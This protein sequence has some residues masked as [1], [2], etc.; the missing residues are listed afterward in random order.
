MNDSYSEVREYL[1][2][3]HAKNTNEIYGR[4]ANMLS[5]SGYYKVNWENTEEDVSWTIP[6]RGK[7]A[8][9]LICVML[10]SCYLYGGKDVKKGAVMAWSDMQQHITALEEEQPYIKK[11][12]NKAEQWYKEIKGYIEAYLEEIE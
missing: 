11:A 3:E 10:F 8:L 6:F 9:F 7:V 1:R 5:K 4:N 12:V 2:Q